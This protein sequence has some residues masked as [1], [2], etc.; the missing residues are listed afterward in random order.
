MSKSRSTYILK[1]LKDTRSNLD[2]A[3]DLEDPVVT[4][5]LLVNLEEVLGS[6]IEAAY[7]DIPRSKRKELGL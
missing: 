6:Y 7:K 5:A 3:I 2:R 4:W 1:M